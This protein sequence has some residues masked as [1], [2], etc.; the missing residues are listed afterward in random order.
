[1]CRL[2]DHS[3]VAPDEL[4]QSLAPGQRDLKIEPGVLFPHSWKGEGGQRDE[5]AHK[6]AG[7]GLRLL[8]SFVA[9]DTES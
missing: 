1:M 6:S 2:D 8:S 4:D 5:G 7:F 3:E 9:R